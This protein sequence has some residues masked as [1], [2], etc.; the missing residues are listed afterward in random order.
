MSLGIKVVKGM[1]DILPEEVAAWYY[2]ENKLKSLALAYGYQEI[3]MPILEQTELFKRAIGEVTDI[4]EKEMYTFTDKGGESLTLRPEG[5]AQSVRLVLENS[6]LRNQSQRLWYQ[7]PMFRRENPQ[8]GRYRQFYQFGMEAYGL[9]GPDVDVEQI[10]IMARLWKQLG[11]SDKIALQLNSLGTL[12]ERALYREALIKYFQGCA[13]DEDSQRRLHTNPMRIL[14]SKHPMMQE[15]IQKAPNLLEFLGKESLTHFETLQNMLKAHGIVFEVNP[16]IVRG[17]DYYT[18]TVYEWVT[19]HLGS[20]GTVCAGGRYNELVSL[21]GGPATPAV[22]FALGMERLLMLLIDNQ[23]IPSQRSV[24]VYIVGEGE[25]AQEKA[26]LLA[27]TL[28]TALP[29][30]RVL[31]NCGGGSFKS[32]FKRADKSSAQFALILGTNELQNNMVSIKAL[33]K[34]IPQQTKTIEETVDFLKQEFSVS[35]L[36]EAIEN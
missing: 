1:K 30:L 26:F 22:G 6:L 33:R 34:E 12:P 2:I 36:A 21:M 32:Q 27:E 13:L 29:T 20:Q 35:D 8:K 10:L 7:G 25:T 17:L 3:R 28:R 14:D 15:A 18:H 5:T 16:R 11:L 23:L 9:P 24:D 19:S 31:T 4:V